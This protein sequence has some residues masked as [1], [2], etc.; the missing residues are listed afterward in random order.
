M[1]YPEKFKKHYFGKMSTLSE[2]LFTVNICIY[3]LSDL[4]V[5][6]PALDPVN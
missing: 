1:P 5:P 3:L 6:D 2:E 4:T